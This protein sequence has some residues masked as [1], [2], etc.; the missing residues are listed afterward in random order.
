MSPD[1][2]A[3]VEDV[4][5]ELKAIW[6]NILDLITA[7]T[8]LLEP[9]ASLK[10]LRHLL[11]ENVPHGKHERA[12]TGCLFYRQLRPVRTPEEDYDTYIVGW[13]LEIVSLLGFDSYYELV[14]RQFVTECLRIKFDSKNIFPVSSKNFIVQCSAIS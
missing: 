13:C 8:D 5:A 4:T 2:K 3:L 11:E 6:P 9:S 10:Y 14:R 7:Q 1:E 12:V